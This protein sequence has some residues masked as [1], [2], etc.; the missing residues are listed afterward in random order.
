[1]VYGFIAQWR[2]HGSNSLISTKNHRCFYFLIP[3]HRSS[4]PYICIADP[5]HHII[6]TCNGMHPRHVAEFVN[7]GV[8][9]RTLAERVP[10]SDIDED[11]SHPRRPRACIVENVSEWWGR[12][13]QG[14][15]G[16]R[17]VVFL[18]LPSVESIECM[19]GCLGGGHVVVPINWRW[20]IQEMVD[21][22]DSLV[23][24]EIV[25]VVVDGHFETM[26]LKLV[27]AWNTMHALQVEVV[28][29]QQLMS[30][31]NN[32]NQLND[33]CGKKVLLKAPDDVAFVIF[34]SGTTSRPKGAM[35]THDA[36][37][38]QCYN[39]HVC[40]G[41][42]D[43]DV[44]LHMAPMFHV[45]GLVSALAMVSVGAV[46]VCMP[47]PHFDA[48]VALELLRVHS[49]TSFIA[50]PTMMNDL[51][52]VAVSTSCSLDHVERVLIGA[53]ALSQRTMERMATSMPR[54]V[55]YTAYGMTETCSSMTYAIAGN[56]G[57][58]DLG[59]PG[60]AYV[61]KPPRGIHMAVLTPDGRIERE[62][63]GELV[64][65]G[66]HTFL[67]YCMRDQSAATVVRDQAGTAAWFRTGDLGCIRSMKDGT[68]EIWLLG[69]V[70]DMIK[71]GGENVS[72]I[73]VEQ[74]VSMHPDVRECSVFGVPDS[75][76][77]EAVTVAVVLHTTDVVQPQII[78][79][80]SQNN[81]IYASMKAY[82]LSNGLASYKIPKLVVVYP[83]QLP[84]NA[85]GK[86]LK[87][88]LRQT[89][90]SLLQEKRI[91]KL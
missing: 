77:G 21:A 72:A 66:R 81:A 48:N 7:G 14:S 90:I 71:T 82:C 37:I 86:V 56:M 63:P 83:Q 60:S 16:Y 40:C 30:L 29:V 24:G 28:C 38:F 55:V 13:M 91:S 34:T 59:V 76:W 75:T 52:E 58:K 6:I 50:V 61:G 15:A 31:C 2:N 78:R 8:G 27:D 67:K 22:L 88:Q 39:K 23:D 4:D 9:W 84:R 79:A 46:H 80:L 26:G 18:T 19:L 1:M 87:Q 44:Y 42:C 3:S 12:L 57:E 25:Q 65:H 43:S 35:I 32:N 85:T 74:A 47:G 17:F 64:T 62:G 49:C 5:F 51:M 69:R 45:G 53:G 33:T 89:I 70:K 54:A 41:Y 10:L 73:E 68:P 11:G 36:M 20:S